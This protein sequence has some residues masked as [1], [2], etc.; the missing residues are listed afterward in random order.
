MHFPL[1]IQLTLILQW[2]AATNDLF[3]IS[4]VMEKREKSKVPYIYNIHDKHYCR[5]LTHHNLK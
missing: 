5:S 4:L 1:Q 2:T 3:C